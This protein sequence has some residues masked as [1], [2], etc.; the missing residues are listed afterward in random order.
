MTTVAFNMPGV[1]LFRYQKD[2]L[3]K[4]HNGCIFN[5]G[6]GSGKSRTSLAYYY[7]SYGGEVWVQPDEKSSPFEIKAYENSSYKMMDNPPDLYII[8]TAK[9]RDSK[10]WEDELI[11]FRLNTDPK[12]NIYKNKIIIDSWNN[13]K[14][15]KDIINAYFIFDEQKTGQA[16]GAWAKAFIEIAKHNKWVLLSA[17]PGDVWM[18]YLSV[19]IANGFYRNKTDFCSRHVQWDPYVNFP[20]VRSYINEGLL[21]KYRNLLLVPMHSN[22]HTIRHRI[23]IE[24]PFDEMLYNTMSEN[25]WNPFTNEP[26]ETASE[27]CAMQRK[28]VNT[29]PSRTDKVLELLKEHP[30]AI[31]FYRF[32]YSLEALRKALD[33]AHY[34][35]TE[36]NG[37]KHQS[38]LDGDKW[39][40]LVQYTANEAWNCI[41]TDTMIFYE[42]EYSYR[43]IEQCCGR[44][45]RANTPYIDLY[46][47]FLRSNSSIDKNIIKAI[48]TKKIFNETDYVTKDLKKTKEQEKKK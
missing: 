6:V 33:G 30:K 29:D 43:T 19:F 20:K 16:T 36:W 44:I 22:K 7:I 23:S 38:I 5:G 10:E 24:L 8:T 1:S 21:I 45:D 48:K 35:Y 31:I 15:Y 12:L 25:R 46:Y 14:K 4:A 42:L 28:I 32:D 41:R 37:H 40:Y 18:D 9:K 27:Y 47:Y 2:A 3:S 34:P 26:I 39:V 13:I 11:P 17:T